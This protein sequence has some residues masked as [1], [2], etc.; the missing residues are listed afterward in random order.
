[1]WPASRAFRARDYC[2]FLFYCSPQNQTVEKSNGCPVLFLSGSL[3][4]GRHGARTRT[5]ARTIVRLR[6]LVRAERLLHLHLGNAEAVSLAAGTATGR[7]RALRPGLVLHGYKSVGRR[8]R[9]PSE[10][11]TNK[12]ADGRPR[13]DTRG[14]E[15]GSAHVTKS[16]YPRKESTE[17]QCLVST[18]HS[19]AVPGPLI[20]F[21]HSALRDARRAAQYSLARHA[22][23]V[24]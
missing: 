4:R 8:P 1:M 20:A 16:N 11:W 14:R 12:D 19:F 3:V 17:D 5:R 24:E 23:A 21:V 22:M 13:L 9:D 2:R 7:R 6:L 18:S 10:P 15:L